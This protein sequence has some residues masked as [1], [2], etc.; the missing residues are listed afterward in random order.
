MFIQGNMEKSIRV[1]NLIVNL[2]ILD[3]LFNLYRN[4]HKKYFYCF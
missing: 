1:L 3:F 4:K 2:K